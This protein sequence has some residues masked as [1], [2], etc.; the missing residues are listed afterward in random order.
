VAFTI[1]S[2]HCACDFVYVLGDNCS[3]LQDTDPS[4]EAPGLEASQASNAA[5]WTREERER[6]KER[7]THCKLGGIEI[8]DG[9][10]Y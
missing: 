10:P 3:E 6:E 5:V 4:V 8:G 9:G 1:L 7:V 2:F